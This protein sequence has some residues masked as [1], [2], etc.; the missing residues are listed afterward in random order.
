MKRLTGIFLT[1]V[2]CLFVLV[3]CHP[4]AAAGDGTFYLTE[5]ENEGDGKPFFEWEAANGASAYE[6]YRIPASKNPELES[7]WGNP[8]K[9]VSSSVTEYKD[10][11]A[12]PLSRY[13]YRVKAV[14]SQGKRI[15]NTLQINCRLEK[16]E[17]IHASQEPATGYPS[18]SWKKVENADRYK[19]LISVWG[20]F[21]EIAEVAASENDP[22]QNTYTA[23]FDGAIGIIYDVK[24]IACSDL[25]EDFNSPDSDIVAIKCKMPRPKNVTVKDSDD[26]MPVLDWDDVERAEVYRVQYRK[27]GDTS[28][29]WITVQVLKST[30]TLNAEPGVTYDYRIIAALDGSTT[31]FDSR[32]ATGE[33]TCAPLPKFTKQ[34]QDYL[35]F[36]GRKFVQPVVSATGKGIQYDWYV[37]R[38]SADEYKYVKEYTGPDYSVKPTAEDD[39]MLYYVI[40]RDK[41]GRTVRSNT[42]IIAVPNNPVS[43]TVTLGETV[44]FTVNSLMEENII[45]Y[46]WQTLAPGATEW[47]DSQSPSARTKKFGIKTQAGH[48]GYRVRCVATYKN[49]DTSTSAAATLRVKPKITTQPASKTVTLGDEASFTVAA[50]GK[51]PFTYRWQTLAPGATEWKDS[52]NATA[53]KATFKITAQEGHHGYRFRCIVTDANGRPAASTSAVLKVNPKITAQPANRSVQVGNE[54]SFTVAAK[55]KATLKYQWQTLAP[56]A[57]EWKDSTNATAKKAT[58]KITAKAGHNGYKVRCIVT[59]GNGQKATS[60]QAKLTVK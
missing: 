38:P 30:V 60:S 55:G 29:E 17:I 53:K 2:A 40:A 52:T 59:D 1:I 50:E 47:K 19:V 42:G 15:S 11:T 45:D 22:N 13:Y 44:S 3:I 51:A 54:A 24:V 5:K 39:G 32:A 27:S 46:Q 49:G 7:S 43:R 18:I 6:V 16:P 28:A 48:D 41:F 58:F 56:G 21:S 35:A 14:L 8:I 4:A 12:D 20:W 36:D 26:G 57:T 34:P 23:S 33:V 10:T 9:T 31:S 37:Y 25:S